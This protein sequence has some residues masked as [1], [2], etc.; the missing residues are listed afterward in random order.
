MASMKYLDSYRAQEW[1]GQ[2]EGT[3]SRKTEISFLDLGEECG[4][5]KWGV[6]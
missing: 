5:L 6:K 2:H 4:N 3:V 1:L